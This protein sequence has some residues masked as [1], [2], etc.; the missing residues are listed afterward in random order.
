MAVK[1]NNNNLGYT[2]VSFSDIVNKIESIIRGDERFANVSQSAVM[3]V[4]LDN[5]AA[6]TDLTNYYIERTAEESF[7]ET[8]KHLSSVI[9]GAKQLGYV[10]KRPVGS[11]ADISITM[12][13]PD[14]SWNFSAGEIFRIRSSSDTIDFKGTSFV[15]MNSY[16]YI[17][18]EAD[19]TLLNGG[20]SITISKAI[21]E[22]KMPENIS[23]LTPEEI[24]DLEVP[25]RIMQGE[26]KTVT[27]YPGNL[28]GKKYQSYKIDDPSFSNLYGSEDVYDAKAVVSGSSIV[29]VGNPSQFTRVFVKPMDGEGDTVEYHINRRSILVDDWNENAYKLCKDNFIQIGNIPVCLIETNRDTT[30]GLVFGDGVN[31]KLGP[32]YGQVVELQY[33]SVLGSSSNKS[34]VIGSVVEA[35]LASGC[36]VSNGSQMDFPAE[37]AFN[38][39]TNISGGSDFEDILS[40]KE[41]ASSIFQ[42]LDRLVTKKDYASFIKTITSPIHV[43]YSSAWG[44]AEECKRQNVVA[45]PGLMN[46][47]FVTALGSPYEKDDDGNWKVNNPIADVNATEEQIVDAETAA[48]KLFVE[49]NAWEDVQAEAYFD[50]Y[51]KSNVVSYNSFLHGEESEATSRINEF[52]SQIDGRSQLTVCNVYVPPTV[53]FFNLT[54][55]IVL[56]QYVD[57]DEF[58]VNLKN[59]LYRYLNANCGFG[60]SVHISTLEN[61]VQNF[62]EV[63]HCHL[64]LKPT[65]KSFVRST[66]PACI[67]RMYEDGS[68]IDSAEEQ[69]VQNIA[70]SAWRAYVEGLGGKLLRY[71]ESTNNYANPYYIPSSSQNAALDNEG[72]KISIYAQQ[73]NPIGGWRFSDFVYNLTELRTFA[74]DS[75]GKGAKENRPY[76][77]ERSTYLV[78]GFSR[79]QFF[80]G[81]LKDLYKKLSANEYGRSYLAVEENFK[82]YI[83]ATCEEMEMAFCSSMLDENGGITRYSVDNEFA[84][85]IFDDNSIV[86]EE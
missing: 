25:I 34:G 71:F 30:V 11:T 44:E 47:A 24:L 52:I 33:L 39:T 28:A 42:T 80:E 68:T 46:C 40:I 85:I 69:A 36:F 62:Q 54:G 7:I 57:V 13:N 61:I 20:G 48:D 21:P 45:I 65:Q 73:Q 2:N 74:M 23:D 31:Q 75:Q 53:H 16:R 64:W 79:Y 22:D 29:C 83:K 12:S 81:Y 77:Y 18:T 55:Q 1:S 66:E 82:H 49:G 27:L 58:K 26:R 72:N 63:K 51:L 4:I 6:M 37:I 15:F 50:I 78:D 60:K 76:V 86:Q 35:S 56:E 38:L 32:I 67:D 9:V 41:K 43:A 8:A 59:E 84:L 17:L 3:K 14:N 19:C 10:P 5:F 70:V